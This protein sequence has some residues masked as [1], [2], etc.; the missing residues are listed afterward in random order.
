MTRRVLLAA[1]LA[2]V[3]GQ[4]ARPR[5]SI[6]WGAGALPAD[7]ARESVVFPRAYVSCPEAAQA[8]R[9][10]EQGRF[11]HAFRDGDATLWSV[12]ERSGS[13]DEG[14]TVWTR[15]SAD[16]KDSPFDRSTRVPLAIRWPGVLMPRV[17][18]DVLISHVDVLPTLLGLTGLAKPAGLQGRDLADLVR[19]RSGEFPDAVFCEGGLDT[20]G[21]WRALV[22]GFD[23][24]IWNAKLEITGLYNLA[25]DPNELRDLRDERE[26]RLTRDSMW[27][28]AEQ[29]M[30]RVEDG[31]DSHGLR[32]RRPQ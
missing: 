6:E 11:P 1:A 5:L 21:E 32:L 13:V 31:R 25:D 4:T 10:L 29:W 8:L 22:R 19:G 16:G 20:P 7:F 2:P 12:F 15:T 14:I 18:N 17:A 27:A 28:L 26:H 3:W 9:A 30:E 23:K 24:L